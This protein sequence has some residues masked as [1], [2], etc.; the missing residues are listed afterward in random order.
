MA[1]PYLQDMNMVCRSSLGSLESCFY[2]K[3]C[4]S[5]GLPS[6]ARPVGVSW[7]GSGLLCGPSR[8][9]AAFL[10]TASLEPP[11]GW[12]SCKVGLC[13]QYRHQLEKDPGEVGLEWRFG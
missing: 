10:M 12:G 6:P 8:H 5:S 3:C 2:W 1:F 13:G 11:G 4:L 9:T 7:P